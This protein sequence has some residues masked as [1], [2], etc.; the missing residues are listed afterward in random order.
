MVTEQIVFGDN[1]GH[2]VTTDELKILKKTFSHFWAIISRSKYLH[3]NPNYG[4][5]FHLPKVMV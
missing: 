1:H 2:M 5:H 3:K 4:G